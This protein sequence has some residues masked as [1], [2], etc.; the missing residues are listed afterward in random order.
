MIHFIHGFTYLK[1]IYNY[2]DM[3]I[4][5]IWYPSL[6]L[7][8][9]VLAKLYDTLGSR[10]KSV[11]M[12]EEKLIAACSHQM[13][14]DGHIIGCESTENDLVEKGYKIKNSERLRSIS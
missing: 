13:V 3:S 10:Q 2:Y 1:D 9:D 7:G 4:L 5:S 8:Y 11:I 12:M 14:I 6:K